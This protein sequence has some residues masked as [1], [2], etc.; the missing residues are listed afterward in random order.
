MCKLEI[1]DKVKFV[2]RQENIEQWYRENHVFVLPSLYEGFGSVYVEA[3]SSGLP[4]IA[5]S[6]KTGKYSVAADEII[7]T[8]VNGYLMIENDS[9]EL[10]YYLLKLYKGPALLI[11]L[12]INARNKAETMFSWR[13][14]V[15]KLLVI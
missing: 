14:T 10:S 4:C 7:D 12:G 11:E 5:I 3:M 9:D 15:E 6:N 1:E 8:G 2:G 13:K